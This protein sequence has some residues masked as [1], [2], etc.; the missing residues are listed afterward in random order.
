MV[1]VAQ[2]VVYVVCGYG[3]VVGV[4]CDLSVRSAN[5]GV[6]SASLSLGFR[7]SI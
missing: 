3:E 4:V 2:V 6:G 1:L 7:Q 5:V